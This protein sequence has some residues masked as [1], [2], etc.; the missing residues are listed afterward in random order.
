MVPSAFSGSLQSSDWLLEAA[1]W[2]HAHLG[3]QSEPL[4]LLDRDRRLQPTGPLVTALVTSLVTVK[5]LTGRYG[6]RALVLPGGK[7]V[8]G[9]GPAGRGERAELDD[10][11]RSG[12]GGRRRR[13]GR[14]GRKDQ[15]PTLAAA[16][17]RLLAWLGSGRVGLPAR[18]GRLAGCSGRLRARLSQQGQGHHTIPHTPFHSVRVCELTVVHDVAGGNRKGQDGQ[19]PPKEPTQVPRMCFAMRVSIFIFFDLPRRQ[20]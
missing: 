12:P 14:K 8:A 19:S 9:V 1:Q 7:R 18:A 17:H 4:R 11:L 3:S 16:R 13:E 2:R 5:S 20:V 10:G 6:Q 15:D